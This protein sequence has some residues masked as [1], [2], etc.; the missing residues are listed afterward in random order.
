MMIYIGIP[1][2]AV[3]VWIREDVDRT[4]ACLYRRIM[5]IGNDVPNVFI[6]TP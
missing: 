5:R 6:S 1:L 2:A 4:E 3:G